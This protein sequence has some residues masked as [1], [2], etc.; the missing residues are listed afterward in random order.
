MMVRIVKILLVAAATVFLFGA[1]AYVALTWVVGDEPIVRVPHLVGQSVVQSL[2]VLSDMGLHLKLKTLEPSDTIPADHVSHQEPAAGSEIKKGREVWI[3]V[4]SGPSHI[5]TPRLLG[6]SLDQA[7]VALHGTGLCTGAVARIYTET[8]PARQIIAQT[9]EAGATVVRNRCI[10]LLVS[11][12]RRPAAFSMPD[13]IGDDL[14]A[15]IQRLDLYRL[16]LGGV[17]TRYHP[18]RA[19]R[20]VLEQN[21]GAG[22]RVI[23]GSTVS[24][25]VNADS[26]IAVGRRLGQGMSTELLRY[27]ASPGLLNR[28]VVIEIRRYGAL[29]RRWEGFVEPGAQVELLVPRATGTTATIWEDHAL[30]DVR[31]LD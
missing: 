31:I 14:E 20:T 1:S 19:Q 17:A 10:D 27:R 5:A 22:Q 29:Q 16:R 8:H 11:L 30:A 18:E 28:K 24:L 2:A 7:N 21:P 6:Q 13:L 12:G 25:V 9:P 4:S 26:D 23:E 15:S 3:V